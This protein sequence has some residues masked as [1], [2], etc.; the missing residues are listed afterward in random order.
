MNHTIDIIVP[1]YNGAA[2]LPACL[3]ALQAQT[4]RDW[5]VLVVDD[6]STDDSLALLRQHYPDVAVLALPRNG[7][8]VQ[9]VN[10]GIA[11]TSAP[12]VILLNN[13]TEVAPAFVEQL[14]GALERYPAYSFAAPKLRLFAQPDHLHSAGDGYAWDGVPFSRGVW[15]R[16]NGQFDSVCEVF[17]PCAGAAAYRRAAL[18]ALADG[19]ADVLDPTLIMYCED[20]DLNLRARRAGLR[21][22][23]VPQAIVYHH[24]S[25]TG[26]GVLASYYC[27]RNFLLIWAKNLPLPLLLRSLPHVLGAQA[28]ITWLALRHMR[29]AA[30]RA[31]LRGQWAGLKALPAIWRRRQFGPCEAANL[32]NWIG[33]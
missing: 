17:G 12:I 4:R 11:H 24:L 5:R 18:E 10:A 29:G 1:N 2:L 16:D 28:R 20:V 26:G 8:F 33:R 3:D 25:A 7:G 22:L 13:D 9:A 27:G 6:A 30:A 19:V 23:F 31:R 14:V 21:T 32:R 15:Q